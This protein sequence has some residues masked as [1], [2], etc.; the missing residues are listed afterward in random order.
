[1]TRCLSDA[2]Q[3]TALRMLCAVLSLIAVVYVTHTLFD[4]VREEA[5]EDE[6]VERQVAIDDYENGH[7][8]KLW[9]VLGDETLATAE[10]ACNQA[11]MADADLRV[12]IKIDCSKV[13][14]RTQPPF[15]QLPAVEHYCKVRS[16]SA[17]RALNV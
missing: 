12:H 13:Q 9:D 11:S 10:C 4:F 7:S 2:W 6:A 14:I 16:T 15:M 17:I 1:M 5:W 8:Q 3:R